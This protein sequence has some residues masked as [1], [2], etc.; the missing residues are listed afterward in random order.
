MPNNSEQQATTF[1]HRVYSAMIELKPAEQRVAQFF[2]DQ[3]QAALLGSAAQIAEL[4]GVSDATVVRAARA[5]GF[6]SL[7]ALRAALLSELSGSTSPG[8]RL[9]R[10]LAETDG[11]GGSALQHVIRIHEN[12]LDVLRRPDIA[13]TFERAVD[14]LARAARRHVFGIGPSGSMADYA[15][16]QFNRI[17]LPTSALSSSGIALADHLLNLGEGDAVLM[18]AYAPLYREVEVVLEMTGRLSLPVVLISDNLGPFVADKVAEILPVPRGKAD[19][20]AMHGG[21]M[22]L[23]E[24]MIIALAGR[25]RDAAFDTLDRLSALRGSIDKAWTKRGTKKKKAPENVETDTNIL[26]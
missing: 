20:L 24:A 4:V 18:M 12:V 2:V 9:A 15:S 25:S 8:N 11:D 10:T 14:I 3:K 7:S 13:E 16:L 6:E 1:E 23:L 5:L 26:K 22:V 21:T 17:G 19:H